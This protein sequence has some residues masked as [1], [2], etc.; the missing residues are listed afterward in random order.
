M[1]ERLI[2]NVQEYQLIIGKKEEEYA[3]A[4]AKR[5]A[6]RA[7]LRAKQAVLRQAQAAAKN[8]ELHN[9]QEELRFLHEEVSN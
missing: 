9:L 7:A 3:V 1:A 2:A 4:C 6:L 5:D 8:A